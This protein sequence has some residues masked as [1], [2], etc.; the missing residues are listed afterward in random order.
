ML[1]TLQPTVIASSTARENGKVS[2]LGERSR[3]VLDAE[4]NSYYIILSAMADAII[5]LGE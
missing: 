4:A 2:R 1:G 3:L 5:L